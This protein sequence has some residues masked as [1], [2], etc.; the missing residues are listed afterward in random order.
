[1]LRLT[2]IQSGG[3]PPPLE[4]GAPDVQVWHGRDGS[5]GAYGQAR[6]G[7][8]WIHLPALASF[9][10]GTDGAQVEVFAH[11]SSDPRRVHETFEDFV[12][13]LALQAR[14]VE[15]LHASA[16]RTPSGI[17]AFCADSTAGKSTIAYGLDR[18]GY[19]AWADDWVALV[20]ADRAVQSLPQRCRLQLRPASASYYGLGP[21]RVTFAPE[22]VQDDAM[23]LAAVCALR[24][25]PWDGRGDI[26]VERLSSANAF[27]VVLAQG[28][29][30]SPQESARK[31]G[32]LEFYLSLAAQVPVFEA[33][34]PTGLERLPALLDAIEQ[35]VI[36]PVRA[37]KTSPSTRGDG[38]G[39]SPGEDRCVSPGLADVA[40][41]SAP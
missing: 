36:R 10:L 6:A 20:R 31:R 33:R 7:Q 40:P 4:P 29:F 14:G 15:V 32:M 12:L 19:P 8:H 27:P 16:V 41:A 26:S 17:V 18:R 39:V 1:M 30:L 34:F 25:E 5:I 21:G 28:C 11:P 3:E 24:R 23:R 35:R 22:R 37:T 13:P 9:R 2:L 38:S